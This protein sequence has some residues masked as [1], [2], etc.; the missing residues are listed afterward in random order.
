M[1]RRLF[2]KWALWLLPLLAVRAFIPVGFMLSVGADGLALVFCPSQSAA[3]VQALADSGNDHAQHIQGADPQASGA[4]HEHAAHTGGQAQPEGH[5]AGAHVGHDQANP[6]CPYALAAVASVLDIPPL[7]A[8]LLRP[9]DE[10]IEQLSVA[11]PT[12]GPLR[13]DRIRGP[14]VLS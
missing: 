12:A 14:P 1:N 3:L 5:H 9:A 13:A 6:L 2:R 10:R 8:A 11:L 7:E 4:L